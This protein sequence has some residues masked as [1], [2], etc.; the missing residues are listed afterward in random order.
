M[1]NTAL[2]I[3]YSLLKTWISDARTE[4]VLNNLEQA[5]RNKPSYK[6]YLN[7]VILLSSSY[8]TLERGRRIDIL[9]FQNY[10][11]KVNQINQSLLSILDDLE[12]G[13]ELT[14]SAAK[15]P[16]Y[17]YWKM[18]MPLFM[19]TLVFLG[20][21]GGGFYYF[22]K[23]DQI[24]T[25]TT[26]EAWT[27]PTYK[28]D[29]FKVLILPFQNETLPGT[30]SP[31]NL[32]A[33]RLNDFCETEGLHAQIG[34]IQPDGVI[35]SIVNKKEADAYIAECD[36]DM[37]IWGQAT[38]RDDK[39]AIAIN[40]SILNP[41]E[42]EYISDFEP[43]GNKETL[44][45]D[46]L[47]PSTFKGTTQEIEEVLKTL[48]K[49]SVAFSNKDYPSVIKELEVPSSTPSFRTSAA[50]NIWASYAKAE[51]YQ[52]TNQIDKAI[53]A[54][55]EVLA[56]EPTATL[57]LNNR[58]HLNLQQEKLDEALADFNTIET[59]DEANYEV[60]Y[61][62]GEIHEKLGN[63]GE[64]HKDYTRAKSVCPPKVKE[65]I[66]NHLQAVD[67][68]IKIEKNKISG[69][70]KPVSLPPKITKKTPNSSKPQTSK[71][72]NKLI[73]KAIVHNKIGSVK[74]A[75]AAVMS[76]LKEEPKN[77]KAIKELIRASYFKDNSIDITELRTVP[78]LKDI[79]SVALIQL[80]DPVVK[81][82]IR[83]ERTKKKKKRE[84]KR[85]QK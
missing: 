38:I 76:V 30:T 54:Y 64:A 7:E 42:F 6:D 36:P 68:K 74:E 27:C 69:L 32:I 44:L 83:N 18:V 13:K 65:Q 67:E 66:N 11:T 85:K 49:V 43:Q 70:L 26:V 50:A 56:V 57:A 24:K 37:L 29:Y 3:N 82:I 53:D 60:I 21:V 51:S 4:E 45:T 55:S 23:Q 47:L 5:L 62:K 19:L 22:L 34:R 15:I 14:R 73:E 84:R 77:K 12:E 33:S 17:P 9:N 63:F 59:L 71:E 20:L 61:K 10:T 31:Y 39:T 79:D 58:G 1:A 81:S 2:N 46:A 52:K 35:K 75:E 8:S 16:M 40:Y 48:L 41:A 78:Y 80:Q 28:K 25:P 72:F